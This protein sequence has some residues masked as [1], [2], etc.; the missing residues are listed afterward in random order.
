MMGGSS[1]YRTG[2]RDAALSDRPRHR[3]IGVR[4]VALTVIAL[5]LTGL[6]SCAGFQV[7]PESAV[8]MGSPDEV[9]TTALELLRDGEFKIVAQDI[10]KHE[11]QAT[12]EIVLRQRIDRSTPRDATDKE[13]HRIELSVR[14]RSNDRSVVEVFYR[15]EK[16]MVED[17]AF[18]FIGSLRDRMAIHARGAAPD[19]SRR[20]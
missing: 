8:I 7:Q 1:Q 18:R 11:L 10:T 6:V 15:I 4:L 3:G 9:W 16:L 19:S 14:P 13:R 5:A 17:A 12:R 2:I 20:R